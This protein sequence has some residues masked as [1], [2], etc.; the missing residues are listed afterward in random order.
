MI[1]SMTGYG[2]GECIKYSRRF[3]VEIKSVN[4]RYNDLT[5]KLPR[6]MNIYEDKIRKILSESISRG[7]TDVY[8]NMDSF[9]SDD[10]KI[11][12]NEPLA[13]AYV[14]QLKKIKQRFSLSDDVSLN[15]LTRF[16]DIISVEKNVESETAATEMFE[17]LTEA[18]ES[19]IKMFLNMRETEGN[20]LKKDLLN[21]NNNL[22][23]L[24]EK[25]KLRSPLV[26]AEYAEKLTAKVREALN[27]VSFDETRLL[28][29]ITVFTDKSCIDEELTRLSS[30][31]VQM[32]TI[33][34]EADSV[35]RKLDFLVQ[36]INREI[37]TIGSKS[38]DIEI[39][40]I[41]VDL[42][43][44]AEKIREQVQNIE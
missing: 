24:I 37:N 39:T 9:S 1:K 7:K 18:L 26:A 15:L 21:K 22:K 29:E 4:H 13:D 32:E 34:N 19:A 25:I 40:K 44:E 8:I 11:N 14:T 23:A 41:V 16:P 17:T 36:E 42:K 20:A 10:I 43:S 12:V 35:G 3:I 6:I 2:R 33:L 38:N 28:T 5:I 30:H 27:L 31:I